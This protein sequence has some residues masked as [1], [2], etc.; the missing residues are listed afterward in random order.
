MIL[1]DMFG[2]LCLLWDFQ[3]RKS[4]LQLNTVSNFFQP[5]QRLT[6]K[7]DHYTVIHKAF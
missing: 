1:D 7:G 2:I 3:R 6:A 4:L 5:Q